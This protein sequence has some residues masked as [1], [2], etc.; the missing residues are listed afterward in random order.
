MQ[1]NGLAPAGS[2]RAAGVPLIRTSGI[3]KSFA[4]NR[5][6]QAVDLEL[7]PGE[8]VGLLGENGAGKSTMMHI[9][10]GGLQADSGSLEMDGTPVRFASVADGIAAGVSFVHQELSVVGALSVAENLHLGRMPRTAAGLV[11][12]RRM[13]EAAG[14]ILARVGAQ[15]IDPARE[16]GTLRTGEQQLVEIARAAAREPRLLIL[17]EPTSSLTPHEVEGFT[18][19]VRDARAKGSA[20]IFITHRLEEALAL[21]DRLLVLRNGAIIS[22]RRPGETNREQL[23]ADMT[24]KPALY[25]HRPRVV[26]QTQTALSLQGVGDGVYLQDIS[27]DIAKGEIFGLFGLVGAGRTELLQLIHGVRRQTQGRVQ[28]F[29][30][31]V[32]HAGPSAAVRAGIALVPEGRKTAGILP[33]HSVRQNASLSSLR[34]FSR[35]WFVDRRAEAD[36][37][38]RFQQSLDIRMA[39]D[40]QR[41]STL[42]GGNQ[43]KVIF[44]R[45]LMSRPK[46][47]LLD[48]P[49]HGVDVGAKADLY[50][51]IA[52]QAEAGLTVLVASSEVPEILALCDR[53]AILSKGR[54]AGI[55]RR[56]EMTEDR[57]L[58][59]A[60]KEH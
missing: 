39:A 20:I 33:Q 9:L 56:D 60:F 50:D 16:A 42:S 29:G 30:S 23:I 19:Y 34:R 36:E 31:T 32:H 37:M 55:L 1:N 53:V 46:L 48:E 25:E 10:S 13:H 5:V 14:A 18:A 44:A 6:L 43:Q 4:G 45:A 41:I 59:M 8:V 22:E 52:R 11:D 21:C 3:A 51:I 57:V 24:G 12:F 49:T 35:R 15:F 27:L 54:L 58:T 7:F 26:A 28:L 38:Q 40:S 47:L 2:S 17:D